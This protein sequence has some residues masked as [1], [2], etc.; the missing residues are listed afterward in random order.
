MPYAITYMWNPKYDTN[1][2]IYETGNRLTNV[3]N[4]LMISKGVGVE[5]DGLGGWDQP[6]QTVIH[7]IDKQQRPTVQHREL[8][9][10]FYNKP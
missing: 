2:R 1:E 10:I 8:Y 6:M 4:R 9:S 5:R 7:R 3:E